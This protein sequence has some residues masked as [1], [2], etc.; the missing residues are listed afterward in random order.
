M[1]AV[2]ATTAIPPSRA[3]ADDVRWQSKIYQ[4]VMTPVNFV[5]FIVSLYLIDIRYQA[6]RRLQHESGSAKGNDLMA[7]MH[8]LLYR[9]R[10][11]PYDWV[12]GYQEQ[13]SLHSQSTTTTTTVRREVVV[14]TSHTGDGDGDGD[15]SSLSVKETGDSW[16]YHTKQKKLF[17]VEAADAFA[18]R[19]WVL[20][21]LCTLAVSAAWV[22]WRTVVFT[23]A[24][25][26]NWIVLASRSRHGDSL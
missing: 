7:W 17:K 14:T 20:F 4:A 8:W 13:S 2:A 25:G 24:L 15:G 9:R 11:S 18:L 1:S 21:A 5:T 22:L 26:K 3:R 19:R 6:R 12:D 23:I 16:F 10:P